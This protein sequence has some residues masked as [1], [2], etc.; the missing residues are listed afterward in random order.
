MRLMYPPWETREHVHHS[1]YP[2]WEAREAYTPP[3]V[4]LREAREAYIHLMY[5]SQ[6]G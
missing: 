5:T 3:Y 4:P 6:G 1:M 2:P